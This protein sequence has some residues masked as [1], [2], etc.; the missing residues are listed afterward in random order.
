MSVTLENGRL[1]NQ[2]IRNIAVSLIAEKFNLHVSYASQ[3]LITNYLGIRLFV[4]E[5][6]YKETEVLT[7]ANYIETLAQDASVFKKNVNSNNDY[8]QTREIMRLGH[9]YLHSD[10]VKQRIMNA[11]VKWGARYNNNNDVFIHVR[12]TDV[13]QYNPGVSYY[14]TAIRSLADRAKNNGNFSTIYIS[15]DD[16]QH[17]IVQEIM[18]TF[19]NC[20]LVNDREGLNIRREVSIIQFGST[21]RYVILSHGSFSATIGHLA[22]NSTVI[23]PE[24]VPGVTQWYGDMF[25]GHGWT[26][27]L[28]SEFNK[29]SGSGIKNETISMM[30][31]MPPLVKTF[32]EHSTRQPIPSLTSSSPS[33]KVTPPSILSRPRG[34][35]RMRMQFF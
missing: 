29:P 35:M 21:C 2:I 23:Y 14:L 25:S 13:A 30:S 32:P 16:T 11:N 27:I 18:R 19:K 31:L 8:F 33:V 3:D 22:F 5:N 12:L 6:K 15:S 4:G 1:G 34:R 26:K 24:H 17:P 9:D 7:D 10:A 20:K 28:Y